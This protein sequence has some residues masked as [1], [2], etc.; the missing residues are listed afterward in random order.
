MLSDEYEPNLAVFKYRMHS[1]EVKRNLSQALA[2]TLQLFTPIFNFLFRCL[3][4]PPNTRFP[5][6]IDYT[7]INSEPVLQSS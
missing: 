1:R 6:F 7:Q 2:S 5:A 4:I 3:T